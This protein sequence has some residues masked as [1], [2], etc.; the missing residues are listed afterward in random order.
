MSARIPALIVGGTGYVAGELLRLV[1]QHPH[2]DLRGVSSQSQAGT[3]VSAAFPHLATL[4]HDLPF[5]TQAELAALIEGPKVA[6]FSA[7]PHL[8]SAGVVA[9]LLKAASAAGARATVVDVSSDFRFRNAADF[10]SVYK[11]PHGAP[12]LL[13]EFVCALPEHLPGIPGLHVGHPGCFATSML[14]GLVPL[15]KL[16]LCD[17]PVYAAGITGST[18]AGRTPIAT[19]HHPERH[20]NLFAYNPL[21]HRHAPEVVQ[22]CKQLTGVA[23]ELNFV[24]HSGPF[25]R[26]IHMTLQARLAKSQT[27]DQLREAFAGFYTGQEFVRVVD[28]MPRIKDVAGSNYCHIGVTASGQGIAV[29]VAIDNLLKGAAGGA[30]QWMNRLLN[31]PESAGLTAPAIGWI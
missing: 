7:A 4:V 15:L 31:M 3:Q 8:V 22:I 23:P 1:A 10:Q 12:E 20:S 28:G 21:K 6:L 30:V 13:P 25:A 18:G 14:A 19:T 16:G 29:L 26:G 9:T 17:G 5:I 24:P 27:T 2:L 11:E